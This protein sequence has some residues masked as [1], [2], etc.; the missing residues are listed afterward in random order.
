MTPD[1]VTFSW[2]IT[3]TPV[4]VTGYKPTAHFVIDT[5]KLAA[6]GKTKLALLEDQLFGKDGEEGTPQLPLPD[7]VAMFK[8]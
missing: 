3:T 6:E 2:D 4:L 1:L 8:Y 5:T 7:A